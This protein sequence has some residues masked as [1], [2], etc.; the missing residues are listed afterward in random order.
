MKKNFV[1][2]QGNAYL[3]RQCIDFIR[4]LDDNTY[5]VSIS[6][7]GKK[8]S[9]PQNSY[10]WGVVIKILGWELGYFEGEIHESLKQM[11][12]PKETF[13]NVLT[14][15]GYVQPKSTSK[16]TTIE[17]ENY[18][19]AIRTWAITDLNIYIPEPNEGITE[20][21]FTA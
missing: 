2:D 6:R 18:L 19:E 20:E 5:Y 21:I 1:L 11:F 10:Y 9:L 7:K 13:H 14:D 16:Y 8:R 3:R 17:F 12:G 4:A 15:K